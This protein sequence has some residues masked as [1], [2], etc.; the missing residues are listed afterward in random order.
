MKPSASI[1]VSSFL[2]RP[3]LKP[4]TVSGPSLFQRETAWAP[5]VH[6]YRGRYYLF[7]TLTS[8]QTLPTPAGRPPNV[9]RG[10]EILVGDSPL[11]PFIP[12]AKPLA[13]SN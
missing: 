10:T 2:K 11:G 12:A 5:E 4:A 1:F 7:V 9:R 3:K 6:R 13:I 8:T